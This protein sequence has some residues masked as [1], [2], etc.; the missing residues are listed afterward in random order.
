MPQ[1]KARFSREN[2]RDPPREFSTPGKPLPQPYHRSDVVAD[3]GAGATSAQCVDRAVKQG[4]GRPK[5]CGLYRAT[6]IARIFGRT[7]RRSSL[8]D[9]S[10]LTVLSFV[11]SLA[12]R[13]GRGGEVRAHCGRGHRPGPGSSVPGRRHH[14]AVLVLCRERRAVEPRARRHRGSTPNWSA[15]S[16][17]PPS[18]SP[19][20][21]RDAPTMQKAFRHH[22]GRRDCGA[23]RWRDRG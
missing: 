4:S 11:A 14:H 18:T 12:D 20:R 15:C 13:A 17:A 7:V 8:R 6:E 19:T 21:C 22:A 2:S 16:T 3:A 9:I 23:L 5:S 1:Q 10:P